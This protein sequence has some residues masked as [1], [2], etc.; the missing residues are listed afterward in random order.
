MTPYT[1]KLA[2]LSNE[3]ITFILSA[4]HDTD[5]QK[6]LMNETD[7]TSLTNHVNQSVSNIAL[8]AIHSSEVQKEIVSEIIRRNQPYK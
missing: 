2:S 5:I 3:D 7:K 6:E 4:I 8:D 1:D